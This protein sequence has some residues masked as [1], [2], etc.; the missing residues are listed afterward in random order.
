LSSHDLPQQELH[1]SQHPSSRQSPL[2]S[3]TPEVSVDLQQGSQQRQQSLLQQQRFDSSTQFLTAGEL[4]FE[5][6][7]SVVAES[8]TR[9]SSD[10]SAEV[11][12]HR[13][14]DRRARRT[15][16]GLDNQPTRFRLMVRLLENVHVTE[17]MS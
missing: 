15:A 8:N 9:L 11:G 3:F 10:S 17:R 1:G 4:P 14:L 16:R 13:V 7:V 2:L 6:A 5:K 12:C